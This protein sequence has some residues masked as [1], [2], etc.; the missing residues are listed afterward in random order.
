MRQRDHLYYERYLAIQEAS[1]LKVSADKQ[2][3]EEKKKEREDFYNSLNKYREQRELKRSELRRFAESVCDNY[4][5]TALNAI[6]ISA[7]QQIAP[8]SEESIILAEKNTANY[9]KEHGGA[10]SIIRSNKGRTSL[11]DTIFEAVATATN[12][13]VTEF[14]KLQEAEKE[15]EEEKKDKESEDKKEDSKK[16]D[17]DDNPAEG[18]ENKSGEDIKVGD[19]DGDGEDDAEQLEDGAKASK[20]SEDDN[21]E[22][23]VTDKEDTKETLDDDKPKDDNEDDKESKDSEDKEEKNYT[24][25]LDDDDDEEDDSSDDEDSD[26]DDSSDSEEDDSDDDIDV[27]DGFKAA[28]DSSDDSEDDS[29]T[30]DDNDS[31]EEEPDEDELDKESP[32]GETPGGES[33]EDDVSDSIDDDT[34]DD[35]GNLKDNKEEMFKKLENDAEVTDAVD[36]IAKRISDAETEFIQR[37]AEDKKKIEKIV[38]RVDDR[39]KAVTDSD[40]DPE[41]KE[42]DIESAQQEATRMITDIKEKRFHSIFEELVKDNFDYIMKDVSLKE[43]YTDINGKI[44]VAQIVESSRVMYGFLEF[45]NT[46]QLEKVNSEYILKVIKNQI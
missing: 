3:T 34:L 2:K 33:T 39:I 40:K 32:D 27:E 23:P 15:E 38:D 17:K 25:E 14:L 1:N 26:D 7:L 46:I 10:R 22:D 28:D 24:D 4:M 21:E 6:Y 18:D 13:D 37:N 11:L 31:E 29:D 16:D 44:N 20:E 19:A 5:E 42:E 36:I 8:L 45:V 12:N 35:D 30:E 9:I 43:S 41:A